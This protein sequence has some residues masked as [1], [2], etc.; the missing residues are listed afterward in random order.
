MHIDLWLWIVISQSQT[1]YV[2]DSKRSVRTRGQNNTSACEQNLFSGG[3]HH[4]P[5]INRPRRQLQH[6]IQQFSNPKWG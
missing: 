6:I 2:G 4:Q 3:H 5:C 1:L